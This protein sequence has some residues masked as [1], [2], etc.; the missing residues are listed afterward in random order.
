MLCKLIRL[1]FWMCRGVVW[2]DDDVILNGHQLL[3]CLFGTE[4]RSDLIHSYFNLLSNKEKNYGHE[5]YCMS[6][7]VQ[8][9][10]PNSI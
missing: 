3:E 10:N 1:I 6:P 5:I 7:N 2:Q 9:H 4:L 8:V